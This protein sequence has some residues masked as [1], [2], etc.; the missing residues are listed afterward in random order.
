MSI[1]KLSLILA[2]IIFLTAVGYIVISRPVFFSM[3][4]ERFDLDLTALSYS[5]PTHTKLCIPEQLEVCNGDTCEMK[6]PTVFLLIDEV[7]QTYSRCDRKPCDTYEVTFQQSGAYTIINPK[8]PKRGE[9][10][11]AADGTYVETNSLLGVVYINR[12]QCGKAQKSSSIGNFIF[13][14]FHELAIKGDPMAQLILGNS[15]RR[16]NNGVAQNDLLALMWY[17][18]SSA[19][20]DEQGKESKDWLEKIMTPDQIAQ[21]QESARICVSSNYKNCK[22]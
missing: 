15:Y 3:A 1:K 14:Y 8:P 5:L 9:V 17:N 18:V 7:G 11:L 2:A 16:G 22:K 21:A 13:K 19:N 6:K 12:G 10:R 4:T 20:G